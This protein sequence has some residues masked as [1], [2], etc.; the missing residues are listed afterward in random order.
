MNH[1]AKASVKSLQVNLYLLLKKKT[2]LTVKQK[3]LLFIL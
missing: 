2:V 3:T 1:Q